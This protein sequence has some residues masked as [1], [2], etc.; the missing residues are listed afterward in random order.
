MLLAFFSNKKN[1][2]LKTAN[3]KL[4]EGK[5]NDKSLWP[6]WTGLHTYYNGNNKKIY[7]KVI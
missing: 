4:E 3:D 5:N 1:Y 2:S 7:N 6:L